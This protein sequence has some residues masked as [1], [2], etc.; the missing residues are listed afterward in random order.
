MKIIAV[1]GS[2]RAGGV[3]DRLVEAALDGARE[4]VEDLAKRDLA[5]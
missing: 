3:T 4:I 2:Y 1:V 5:A